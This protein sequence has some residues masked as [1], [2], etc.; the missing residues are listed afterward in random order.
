VA[1]H[2]VATGAGEASDTAADRAECAAGRRADD[3]DRVTGRDA[4]EGADAAEAASR[5]SAATPVNMAGESGV[6]E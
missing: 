6:L 5:T 4:D 3:G 1:Q 2:R